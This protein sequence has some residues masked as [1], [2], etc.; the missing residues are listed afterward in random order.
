[1]WLPKSVYEALPYYYMGLGVAAGVASFLV[2]RWLWPEI[3]AVVGI[4]SLIAGL[5]LW[6]KRRDYRRSRSRLDVGDQI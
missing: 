6:L 5:V 4:V 3:I 1:M 2:E